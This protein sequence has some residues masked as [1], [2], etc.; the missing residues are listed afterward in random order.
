MDAG[1]WEKDHSL[2]VSEERE[3]RAV[4]DRDVDRDR[5]G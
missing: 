1:S 2:L 4:V 3:T 5:D